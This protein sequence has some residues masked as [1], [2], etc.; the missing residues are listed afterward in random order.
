LRN[1]SQKPYLDQISMADLKRVI[2]KFELP[3]KVTRD[4]NGECLL[5]DK[6]DKWAILRL[7][8]DNYLDSVMT[9][10]MYELTGKGIHQVNTKPGGD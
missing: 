2:K 1:I 4:H 3:V 8:D 9:K 7:L 5:Y 10:Q 6:S